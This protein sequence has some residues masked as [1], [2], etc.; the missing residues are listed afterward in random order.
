MYLY[1]FIYYFLQQ[2]I[3][4]TENEKKS[5]MGYANTFSSHWSSPSCE[6]ISWTGVAVAECVH[7]VAASK[8]PGLCSVQVV[9]RL[10]LS[11]D[12]HVLCGSETA[13]WFDSSRHQ[14]RHGRL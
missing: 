1:L 12:W 13:C 14:L 5:D 7:C 2:H 8:Y 6:L 11:T 4:P 9:H 10:E 3:W